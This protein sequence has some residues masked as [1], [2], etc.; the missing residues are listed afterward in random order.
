[1]RNLTDIQFWFAR[2]K[3]A[4]ADQMIVLNE[5]QQNGELYDESLP[6]RLQAAYAFIKDVDWRIDNTP[7]DLD[8]IVAQI[9]KTIAFI[10]TA[11]PS[12]SEFY[13]SQ[14]GNTN[15]VIGN[16]VSIPFATNTIYGKVRLSVA[17]A[18]ASDPIVVGDNDIRMGAWDARIVTAA[19]S[20]A[21]VLTL[22]KGDGS[23][24][25]TAGATILNQSS[26]G[27]AADFWITGI[28]KIEGQVTLDGLT[29]PGAQPNVLVV[30]ANGNLY[31]RTLAEFAGDINIGTFTANRAI[32]SNGSGAL[33]AS[34][35]T[36]TELGYVGGVTSAIQTQLNN[37]Q[38]LDADLTA[39]AA[40]TGNGLLRKSSGTWGMDTATYLTANQTITLSGDVS[41]SGSTA[42]TTTIA[43][44]A[45]TFA[46]MQNVTT[47]RL[48]GR[49][50]SGTGNIEELLVGT[51]LSLSG[52]TLTNTITQY[53]DA[54]ARAA[55]SLTVTGDSGAATYNNTTGVLN[56]PTYTLDGL[57]GITLT[58]LSSTATG[59]TYNNTTGV[60]SLTAGY[61]IPTTTEQTNWNTAYNNSIVS[62]AFDT[63]NGNLTLT[64][65]DGGTIVQDLDGRYLTANQTITLTG[66][67]TGSGSTGIATTIANDAVT[68][69]K[70]QNVS[71]G[72]ILGRSTASSGNIEEISVGTG[73]V[74]SA[75][76]LSINT[77]TANRAVISDALG[78]LST[79][80]TTAT[81]IGYLSTTTSDVQ[82]QLNNKQPL[83]A[84]LTALA[85][86]G[87]TTIG[88]VVLNGVDSFV[89]RV[90]EGSAN[91]ITINNPNGSGTNPSI[92]IASN[93]AG[94]S[95]IT[96]LG[97]ITSGVWNGSALGDA[98]ILSAANWNEAYDEH[99]NSITWTTA[100]GNLQANQEDGGNITV[101]LDGRYVRIAGETMTGYLTLVGNP[102]NANHAANKAYVD[103]IGTGIA[104]KGGAEAATTGTLPTYI[105]TSTTL[106]GS[107]NG[108]LP[109]Q[110][111]VTL[112]NG[113]TLLVKNEVSNQYNGLYTVTDVGSAGTPYILTR[114]ANSDIWD[115]YPR[116]TV[117]VEAGSTQAGYTYYCTVAS[118]GTL[119][120]TPI[121]YELFSIGSVYLAGAGID[122]TGN[123]ISIDSGSIVD[124]MVSA[125]AAIT[126]TKLA[127]TTASRAL[128]SDGSGYIVA[129]ATTATEV[130]YLTGLSGNA[131]TQINNKQPLDATLTALA[132]YNTNGFLV[133]TAAD[134]FVGRTLQG[135]TDRVTITNGDGVSGSPIID[136]SATYVG[137]NTITTLGTIATGVWNGT[138]IGDTYIS[139]ATNWNSAYNNQIVS[140]SFNTGTGF[141]TLTQLDTGSVTANLDGRYLQGNQTITLSGEASG[142]GATSIAVTLSNSAVIGKVL[143]GYVSGAGVVASTDTILQAIQKI[144]GNI[145]ALI[146]GVS[147]VSGTSNRIT[148][149][150]TTGAV[151][152]DI[153]STYVGQT[154]ITT[155]GTIGT[156][157]WQGTAIADAYI[158]SA[159]TWNAKIGGSGTIGKLAK[160]TSSGAVGDSIVSE[161]GGIVSIAGALVVNND[162]QAFKLFHPTNE[163]YMT[164]QVGSN[165]LNI[166]L[167][168]SIAFYVSNLTH[169]FL[170]NSG[171]TN[172]MSL[173]ATELIT[174][175]A[176]DTGEAHIFGGS[177]RV[178]G[179]MYVMSGN[180]GIGTT[181]P[182]FTA[183]NRTVLDVNGSL[184]SIIGLSVG[185]ATNGFMYADSTNISFGTTQNIPFLFSTNNTEAGR[186]S[187]AGRWLLGT[188]TDDGVNKLQ[189]SGSASISSRIYGGSLSLNNTG[190]TAQLQV[191]GTDGQPIAYLYNNTGTAGQV[192]GVYIEAGTNASDYALS[193]NSSAG[194]NFFTILGTGAATFSSSV[195]A[196]G[197]LSTSDR[198]WLNG[199]IPISSWLSN[200]LTASYSSAG[201]YGWVNSANE[202][203]LGV[204]GTSQLNITSSTATFS[205]SVTATKGIFNGGSE[206]ARLQQDDGFIS[207]YNTANSIRT[208]YLQA[209]TGT[210]I[211]LVAEGSNVLYFGAGGSVKMTLKTSGVLN[212][213]SLPTSSAGLS[214]GDLWNDDSVVRIG[215]GGTGF[216]KNQSASA[217]SATMWITGEV[218]TNSDARIGGK[219]YIGANG[220]YIEEVLVGSTYELRVVDSAGNTTVIS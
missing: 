150:P 119:G 133:Q 152:V 43:N 158:S 58:D 184:S 146:T 7:S 131:Q 112:V 6:V 65:Q 155:L 53:T 37:K 179:N 147:S 16:G 210:D 134:T 98:Y 79:S 149:S 103:S 109:A 186:I 143:T 45:V 15:I 84:T 125:S 165:I 187:S 105:P 132:A 60:F 118:G 162:A 91:R 151:V 110:D 219:V 95:S 159:A 2:V 55:I 199:N 185:G 56:I 101:N 40:L 100:T 211:R 136:I 54:M 61:V 12:P 87:N 128:V 66:D 140:A 215:T 69:A 106:T 47:N 27:Q 168:N 148:A 204:N 208:G 135:V 166:G 126:L 30:D 36:S 207:F 193:V 114:K 73:L 137:Q 8:T 190:A 25:T 94:Q 13:N 81:Q 21:G 20:P 173:S 180:V 117:F 68:F 170:T 4:F 164:T 171:A 144:N 3:A 82:T 213:A 86:I 5:A 195:T 41:G 63:S 49:S 172:S 138:A 141:L 29:N 194:A 153:A 203:R 32:I 46:K 24:I 88:F 176:T 14:T 220:A 18:V 42:I 48:L 31:K 107:V 188:T 205:S 1:M 191:K 51:G 206:L 96:T 177:A 9:Y 108:A 11:L 34:A 78:D 124:S 76:T 23:T 200:S 145:G 67:V 71:S 139:S 38:P 62:V 19:F 44:D 50:T 174:F 57:G 10:G 85:A 97:T 121:T 218:K 127:A 92:D 74:L 156:G 115:E 130:G 182:N 39:I 113:D 75:G 202:L 102:I 104:P 90:L 72:I 89:T 189:V 129:S 80:A 154:S 120:T 111:G 33:T 178:N 83:D 93:Y 59:L 22:T 99:I 217:Q 198:L 214:A 201:S 161:S 77:L 169:N 26:V 35:V 123:T 160:F 216:I 64:Q 142:S 192:K 212:L 209:N 28:A 181:S 183:S 122:I 167:N 196:V 157:V 163:T 197:N 116:A 17:A 52:G 175:N 70:M